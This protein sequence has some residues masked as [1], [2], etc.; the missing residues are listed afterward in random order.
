MRILKM[1]VSINQIKYFMIAEACT[2]AGTNRNTLLRW[3]REGRFT[4]VKNRDRNGW[5]LFTV[6]DVERLKNEVTKINQVEQIVTR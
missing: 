2:I 5:R 1:S 3:I 4:D 6:D